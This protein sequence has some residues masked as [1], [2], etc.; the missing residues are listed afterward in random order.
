[1]SALSRVCITPF[2]VSFAVVFVC[3]FVSRVDA[4][5]VATSV[6]VTPAPVSTSSTATL[7]I[8]ADIV[9]S[10]AA[11]APYAWRAIAYRIAKTD[12]ASACV[13]IPEHTT[14]GTYTESITVPTPA[15]AGAY[16]IYVTPY[17]NRDCFNAPSPAFTRTVTFANAVTVQTVTPISVASVSVNNKVYDGTTNAGTT[18]SCTLVGSPAGVTCSGTGTF[19]DKNVGTGKTVTV[20]GIVLSGPNAAQYSL[21]SAVATTTAHIT[22]APLTVTADA[23]TRAYGDANPD[24]TSVVSGFVGGE[25]VATAGVSGAAACTSSATPT[26]AVGVVPIMCTL[27][28]LTATNYAFTN[29]VANTLT[30]TQ[31]SQS[32]TFTQLQNKSFG[33]A[34]ISLVATA[35]SG[36]LVSY[37]SQTPHVCTLTGSTLR[38]VGVGTC[39]VQ[40]TQAGDVNFTPAPSVEQS[41][42]ISSAPTTTTLL[43]P[44][45]VAYAASAQT[46]CTARVS[47]P[48]LDE[49][50]A[51]S[52]ADNTSVGVATAS[53]RFAGTDIYAPSLGSAVFT[54]TPDV[55]APTIAPHEPVTRE[56]T[57]SD[58]A[59]VAYTVPLVRDDVDA[60][61][62]AVCLPA[63][64]SLFARGSTLVTC[65]A[66]DTS[67]NA[68]APVTFTVTVVDTTK[69]VLSLNGLGTMS[70]ITPA[71]YADEGAVWSD[72]VDGSGSVLGGGEVHTNIP[73]VYTLVY[74]YTDA[75]GNVAEPVV[76]TVTVNDGEA[77]V[78][79]NV[80]STQDVEAVTSSGA[81]VIFSP[82]TATDA[83]DG[84]VSVSC[85]KA[86]GDTF[87]LG[88]IVVRC[89][90]SDAAGHTAYASWQ[91]VVRDTT[92]P[93]LTL[94]G[95]ASVTHDAG[96]DYVE[97]GAS[98]SDAVD[99]T[100]VAEVSGVVDTT[101]PGE[102]TRRYTYTDAAG[103]AAET[104]TR[105]VRIIDRVPPVITAVPSDEEV[106]AIHA[107]G[108]VV[109][110]TLPAAHDAV[111][112][113]VAVACLPQSGSVFAL[114]TTTVT[115]TSSDVVQNSASA[116]FVV[117][118]R[119]TTRPEI[120]RVGPATAELYVGDVYSDAGATWS[121]A[122]D[123]VGSVA[124]AVIPDTTRSGTTTIVYAYTD[125]AGNVGEVVTRTVVVRDRPGGGGVAGTT[126]TFSSPS[127]FSSSTPASTSTLQT[128]PT[129]TLATTTTIPSAA[130][131]Q[132]P[133]TA[134]AAS[135]QP[136]V[137]TPQAE[138]VQEL[139]A[140][141]PQTPAVV[142]SS[143][144]APLPGVVLGATLS[145]TEISPESSSAKNIP[146]PR[147][148][149]EDESPFSADIAAQQ[150]AAS[151]S[152]PTSWS[153]SALAT[154]LLAISIGACVKSF[155][156][157]ST[158]S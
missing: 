58:G 48:L 141:S 41:F 129:T 155:E 31:A 97:A 96:S 112:G 91:I 108:A 15:T 61:V 102:Y 29:F 3:L 30:I 153:L 138:P 1:M 28:T 143:A 52:Y 131:T 22:K 115:C 46:P 99:G 89:E 90:A 146:Q 21:T 105:S 118:V 107:E 114:G 62:S 45:S 4:S 74:T 2:R 157:P 23:A 64:N 60:A 50:V 11:S 120:A 72:A 109:T 49:A 130:T 88:T 43:C 158:S 116:T 119:D 81:T 68:A 124:P 132:T 18:T 123:G 57:S 19:A 35:S 113:D 101:H 73:G 69:P 66:A 126:Y 82:P 84:E 95:D 10:P 77:P 134:P 86:S 149:Y 70:L 110:Y 20:S 7:S 145:P 5:V 6:S 26:T 76:R 135:P 148:A 94:L 133:S 47:G 121:D 147:E 33:D 37:T 93:A 8:T 100:G 24:F 85:D 14:P 142:A 106:E 151:V 75:A 125:K 136:Q 144:P 39:T 59:V 117:N 34:D 98:W 32:I 78:F 63:P 16:N 51:V 40:A 71:S 128:T 27:G 53:A 38:S 111:D 150:A 42:T 55:T 80:P 67:G 137:T 83:V 152:I 103:N 17:A 92:P 65:A 36:I 122:V 127:T 79:T 12:G 154:V 54:I 156:K 139:S 9:G 44:P 87:S 56:A 104:L 140:G 13:N 25:S